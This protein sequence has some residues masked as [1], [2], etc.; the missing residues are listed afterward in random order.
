MKRFL[1][2]QLALAV[3]IVSAYAPFL[4]SR[5]VRTAGDEK[6]YVSQAVEMARDGHWFV[7]TLQDSPDYY[8]G[9][10]HYVLLRI[11]MG[12]F[13]NS[14]WAILYMNLVFLVLGGWAL[15]ALVRRRF[16]DWPEGA[17]FL[18][19]A[20]ALS[21]GV[22]S[23]AYASQME[24]ELAGLFALA[25]YLLDGSAGRAG[26]AFWTVA[27]IA[28]WV[29]APLH[30]AFLGVSAVAFWGASGELLKRAKDP[31]CWLAAL[32][33]VILCV[34]GYLPA[35]FG[36]RDNF[37]SQYLMKELV[38][39]SSTHQGPLTPVVST[40][41]F[42][43]FPWFF[44]AT[45]AYVHLFA[46]AGKLFTDKVYRRLVS[47]IVLFC[48][49]SVLFFLWHPYRFE[50]YN[51]PVISAVVLLIGIT[52]RVT[53]D[54]A[55][56]SLAYR[57]AVRATGLLFLII[58]AGVTA[59]VL[60]LSPLP[61]WWPS[62]LLPWLW[63]S[64]AIA[65]AG[66][67]YAAQ[68]KEIRVK[69]LA[70]S[71]LGLYWALGSFFMVIGEREVVDLRRLL[72]EIPDASTARLSYVN[73]QRNIWSEW[74]ILRFFIGRPVD[75][76]HTPAALKEAFLRGDLI[77][78]AAGEGRETFDRFMS[79]TLPAERFDQYFWKRWRTHGESDSGKPL[80]KD[81][82]DKRDLTLFERDYFVLKRRVDHS[83][84][85]G[86]GFSPAQIPNQT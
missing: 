16:P 42:Y 9:P 81:A 15:G 68:G 24:I 53:R 39:K 46:G 60:R 32:W 76:M 80:W 66:W 56:W 85:S 48:L 84:I 41:G 27:G 79:E 62:W 23:H 67:W 77:L 25:L 71:T 33:G 26:F 78:V 59:I 72:R 6:V 38:L 29:K 40:F 11:G 75:G 51:I 52:L 21:V 83:V 12:T 64:S 35:Y 10:L 13:G 4:G 37:I 22:Y 44:L 45:L 19:S 20:F 65:V 63:I 8:K 55:L 50:N 43:L 47:L 3:L 36:D 2:W 17:L 14:P 73:L 7:Q 74:G 54:S 69:H 31:R 30:S 1:T 28:G 18:G 34:A 57:M 49:P 82:W 58:P 61:E 5:F 70:W 86:A